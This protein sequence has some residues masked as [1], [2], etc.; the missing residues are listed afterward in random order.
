MIKRRGFGTK[1]KILTL[2]GAIFAAT[3]ALAVP[4]G[5]GAAIDPSTYTM[6]ANF[7]LTP[8]SASFYDN[9]FKSGEMK[10]ET[11]A[12]AAYPLSLIHI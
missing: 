10:I 7:S 12:R 3:V 6:T 11:S 2:F 4:A 8:K 9:A 1:M 5:A